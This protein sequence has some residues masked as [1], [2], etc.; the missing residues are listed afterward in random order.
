MPRSTRI[1]RSYWLASS[2]P[3][4]S[5]VQF[6]TFEMPT[7]EP[8]FAGLTNKGNGNVEWP[9]WPRTTVKYSVTGRPRS[10]SRR[11]VTSLSIDTADASTP[12]PTYGRSASSSSPCT[13]P[14]SPKVPWRTGNTTSIPGFAPGSGEIARGCHRPSGVMKIRWTSYLAGFRPLTMDSAERSDISCSPLRPPYRT[15]TR[16]G[17]IL[18]NPLSQSR[19]HQFDAQNRR[20]VRDIHHGI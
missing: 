3:A 2:R 11:F 14:S 8:R 9:R 19:H 7:E 13:V 20:P 10:A 1:L 6:F 12:A 15:A 4:S 5:S 17:G 16:R 18:E